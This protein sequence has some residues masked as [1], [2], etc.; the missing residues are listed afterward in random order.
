MDKII[1]EIFHRKNSDNYL[2]RVVFEG[3]SYIAYGFLGDKL[4]NETRLAANGNAGLLE[5]ESPEIENLIY[6][7]IEDINET[8]K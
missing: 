2:I 3:E 4:I 8:E 1:K 7:L 5:A 6:L